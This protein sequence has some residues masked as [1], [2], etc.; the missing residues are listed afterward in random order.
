M[1]EELKLREQRLHV[2][3]EDF[4][5]SKT[6]RGFTT[7]YIEIG[8][9]SVAAVAAV[10]SSSGTQQI[11]SSSA[12]CSPPLFSPSLGE[13]ETGESHYEHGRRGG[14]EKEREEDQDVTALMLGLNDRHDKNKEKKKKEKEN[15]KAFSSSPHRVV[16]PLQLPPACDISRVYVDDQLSSFSLPSSFSPIHFRQGETEDEEEEEERYRSAHTPSSVFSSSS[17]ALWLD[18][19]EEGERDCALGGGGEDDVHF[20]LLTLR[21]RT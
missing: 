13:G 12:S 7:L 18:E 17:S 5:H 9:S 2:S 21:L 8:A 20:D 1:G 19:E 4:D 3:I 10:V 15:K 11:S 14:G 6:L 16:L